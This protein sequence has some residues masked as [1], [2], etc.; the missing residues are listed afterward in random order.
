[1]FYDFC[2]ENCGRIINRNVKIGYPKKSQCPQCKTN[3]LV[4]LIGTGEGGFILK[5]EGFY[6]NDK[7]D[8]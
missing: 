7:K 3:N 4:R 8:K 6:C 1:M 2:C 5:G